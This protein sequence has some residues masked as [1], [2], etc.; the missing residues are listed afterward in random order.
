MKLNFLLTV[1]IRTNVHS[2][3]FVSHLNYF[4][5]FKQGEG[6]NKDVIWQNIAPSSTRF[7]R[8]VSF[9]HCKETS[10][11]SAANHRKMESAIA[12]LSPSILKLE[13]KTVT[14]RHQL[15]PVM[16]DG[17]VCSALAGTASTN[18]HVCGSTPKEMN[19]LVKVTQKE[20]NKSTFKFGLS[21]LHARI[22]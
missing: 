13:D 17:K 9:S 19:D 8:P 10:E 18:C 4:R 2:I 5:S 20:V 3:S 11:S 16:V 21:P 6:E 22:R 12:E 7:C 14:V 15:L 1:Y